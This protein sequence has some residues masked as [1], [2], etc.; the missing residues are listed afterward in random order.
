MRYA[1]Q[2][3]RF[4]PTCGSPDLRLRPLTEIQ[5]NARGTLAA[6]AHR[7]ARHVKQRPE[8]LTQGLQAVSVAAV[9]QLGRVANGVR[10]LAVIRLPPDVAR[11]AG[12]PGELLD[13]D[14]LVEA[15]L[16]VRAAQAGLLHAAPGADAGAVRERVVVDPDHPRLDLVR[17]ALALRAVLGPD[18]GPE[19]ELGVVGELYRL[20]LGIDS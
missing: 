8:A 11:P 9:E 14:A 3:S 1:P 13:V 6:L 19:P 12:L 17:H 20:L 15:E 16:G 4:A 2:W 18:R 5:R 10:E 7:S